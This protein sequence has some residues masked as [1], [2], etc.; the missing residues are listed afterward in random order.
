MI[1]CLPALLSQA[2]RTSQLD[3]SADVQK[4]GKKSMKQ[5]PSHPSPHHGYQ[6]VST[7]SAACEK[8]RLLAEVVDLTQD[9]AEFEDLHAVAC[10]A[11]VPQSRLA[12]R[13]LTSKP[14]ATHQQARHKGKMSTSHAVSRTQHATQ[15]TSPPATESS[16]RQRTM[17]RETQHVAMTPNNND[18]D[19]VYQ[20]SGTN[21]QLPVCR[22]PPGITMRSSLQAG[23]NEAS[24]EQPQRATLSQRHTDVASLQRLQDSARTARGRHNSKSQQPPPPAQSHV[25]NESSQS[26]P[27]FRRTA[28]QHQAIGRF[29][30]IGTP[31]P[32]PTHRESRSKQ[33]GIRE[34]QP[35]DSIEASSPSNDDEDEA[36]KSPRDDHIV[37]LQSKLPSR[38]NVL[39]SSRNAGDETDSEVPETQSHSLKTCAEISRALTSAGDGRFASSSE[40]NRLEVSR[41]GRDEQSQDLHVLQR[42]AREILALDAQDQSSRS[43]NE[44]DKREA[45]ATGEESGRIDS[46]KKQAE[47][48]RRLTDRTTHREK[49]YRA[50]VENTGGESQLRPL[51]TNAHRGTQTQHK[52]MAQEA[53]QYKGPAADTSSV[54]HGTFPNANEDHTVSSSVNA[55]RSADLQRRHPEIRGVRRKNALDG[56]DEGENG[57][58]SLSSVQ[59]P[60]NI[61]TPAS[62]NLSPVQRQKRR[63]RST[64]EATNH[65]MASTEHRVQPSSPFHD[66][67]LAPGIWWASSE[68][69]DVDDEIGIGGFSDQSDDGSAIDADYF[70]HPTRWSQDDGEERSITSDDAMQ[71]GEIGTTSDEQSEEQ[72][73]THGAKP[74]DEAPCLTNELAHAKAH[75]KHMLQDLIV[76]EN[77]LS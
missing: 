40:S 18:L 31:S 22:R 74:Q 62:D 60:T 19:N 42:R 39:Q 64:D 34:R 61:S 54:D 45:K 33:D 68:E 21:V 7:T 52:S 56:A 28:A 17:S 23:A 50:D 55:K 49:L 44:K 10:N 1:P 24:R 58:Q 43:A 32:A 70:S 9:K 69:S 15:K 71:I 46:R 12:K 37:S 73:P 30:A 2:A 13:A 25:P 76:S 4:S 29:S 63:R 11:D 5:T 8:T 36:A 53:R 6:E 67:Q 65:G 38:R 20:R 77:V 66:R 59:R 16:T 72:E 75:V 3:G 26:T 41:K 51:I 14:P 27:A 57:Q 48:T 47:R 35:L